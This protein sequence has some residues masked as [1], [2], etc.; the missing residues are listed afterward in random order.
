MPNIRL[1]GLA[2]VIGAVALIA[3]SQNG[4]EYATFD[5]HSWV[6]ERWVRVPCRMSLQR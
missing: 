1:G 5:R 6:L 2:V 4:L 3:R